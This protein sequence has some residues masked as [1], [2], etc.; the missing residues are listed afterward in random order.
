MAGSIPSSASGGR[1]LGSAARRRAERHPGEAGV[2]LEWHCGMDL[3]ALALGFGGRMAE[4]VVAN[5]AQPGG[6]DMAQIAAH[7]FGAG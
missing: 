5:R 6:Q 7:E 4:A 2:E 3:N 1:R